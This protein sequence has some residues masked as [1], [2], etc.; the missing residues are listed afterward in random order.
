MKTTTQP[1]RVMLVDDHY[2]VRMGLVTV[3]QF[4]K[5]IEVAAHAEDGNEAVELFRKHRPDVTLMDVR[6]PVCDGIEATRAIRGE[7]PEARILMLTTYDMDEDLHRAISAGAVGYLLKKASQKELLAAI[8]EVH[9]GGRWLPLDIQE[10]LRERAAMPELTARQM[11]VLGLLVKGFTN[12]EIARILGFSEDGA[13]AHLKAIF[14][15]LGVID[16][17]EAA[18]VAL[19]RGLISLE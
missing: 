11:E 1:I 8:R 18:A 9:R 19:Q 7:F 12:K 6:M 10:R 17:L 15:K 2:V 16:R 5:G 4:D 13:K 3:L 14:T